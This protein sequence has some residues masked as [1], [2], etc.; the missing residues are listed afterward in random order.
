MTNWFV[1]L[2]GFCWIAA[3]VQAAMQGNYKLMFV[4]ICYATATFVL[5]GM[6]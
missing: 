6:K 3:G 5:E 1:I 4:G 2:S